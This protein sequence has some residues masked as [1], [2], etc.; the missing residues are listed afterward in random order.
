[1]APGTFDAFD[2]HVRARAKTYLDARFL[3]SFASL[4]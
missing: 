4:P 1:V 2:A 3:H